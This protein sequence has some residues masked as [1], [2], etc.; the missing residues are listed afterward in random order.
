MLLKRTTLTVLE[1]SDSESENVPPTVTST[2]VKSKT[3][4]T[5][6]KTTSVNSGNM[7]TGV[8]NDST[9]LRER[10]RAHIAHNVWHPT[11]VPQHQDYCWHHTL[12]STNCLTCLL[13]QRR[14]QH[15]Y[16]CSMVNLKNS[17]FLKTL[18]EII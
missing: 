10:K 17:N 9:N 2:S 11:T 18:S 14:S 16:Q 7:V 6:L 4:A 13:C 1:K 15:H 3:T 5:T 12:T 8:L